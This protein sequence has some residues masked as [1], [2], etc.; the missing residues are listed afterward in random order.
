MLA[1]KLNGIGAKTVNG[2]DYRD[3][4]EDIW[5]TAGPRR[6]GIRTMS[7]QLHDKERVHHRAP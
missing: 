6:V 3:Q 4:P 5:F 2:E 7:E 1:E